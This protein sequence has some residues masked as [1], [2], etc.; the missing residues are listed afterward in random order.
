MQLFK[1]PHPARV[2]PVS[3]VHPAAASSSAVA[4]N[5]GHG[6]AASSAAGRSDH[7]DVLDLRFIA[8]VLQG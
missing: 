4:S 2:L 3:P 8:I 5:G 7:V 1:T 6:A